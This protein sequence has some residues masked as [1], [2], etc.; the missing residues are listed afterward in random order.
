MTEYIEFLVINYGLIAVF[1]LMVS[2]GFFSAPPSET[3]LALSGILVSLYHH[4]FVDVFL[5]AIT[6]N[7]IGTY[8]LYLIA[9]SFG[10]EWLFRLKSYLENKNSKFV[11]LF[12]GLIPDE[13]TYEFLASKFREDGKKWV[14][15]FR[16]FPVV[17]SVV[18]IPAGVTKMN[19]FIFLSFSLVGIS[20]WAI[21][22]QSLGYYAVNNWTKYQ[23][24][25]SVPLFVICVLLIIAVKKKFSQYL[26]VKQNINNDKPNNRIKSDR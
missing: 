5:A 26:Y 21:G 12:G 14:C 15:I 11:N 23:W 9:R 20:V 13:A 6:G 25:I 10:H 4:D 22:W 1:F 19:N 18:S 7:L 17:R 3:T 8:I 16:C 2:N 24:Y